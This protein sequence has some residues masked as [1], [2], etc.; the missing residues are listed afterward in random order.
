MVMEKCVIPLKEC[1][2]LSA[3]SLPHASDTT[4]HSAP[5]LY[6]LLEADTIVYQIVLF[7][8]IYLILMETVPTVISITI[9][10]ICTVILKR[11]WFDKLPKEKK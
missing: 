7:F 5:Q 6:L 3:P 4:L 2:F 9:A 8:P 1:P 10:A 11:T